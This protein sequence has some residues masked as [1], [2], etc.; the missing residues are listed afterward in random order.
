LDQDV[1]LGEVLVAL[2]SAF[3]GFEGRLGDA[4]TCVV[5]LLD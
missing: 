2:E 4:N 3:D 5:G 1:I